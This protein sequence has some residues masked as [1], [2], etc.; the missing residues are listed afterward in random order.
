MTSEFQ[1]VL[2]EVILKRKK[3]IS[4]KFIKQK[5]ALS[6][7]QIQDLESGNIHFVNYPYNYYLTKQYI[8]AISPKLISYIKPNDFNKNTNDDLKEKINVTNDKPLDK[9][10]K[11]IFNLKLNSKI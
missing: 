1:T 8:L 10:K 5:T 7:K 6:T 11:I 9:L 3:S 2:S 4:E